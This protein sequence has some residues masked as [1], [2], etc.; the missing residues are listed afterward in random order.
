MSDVVDHTVV[1]ASTVTRG[2]SKSD[3]GSCFGVA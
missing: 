2:P 3:K 1:R